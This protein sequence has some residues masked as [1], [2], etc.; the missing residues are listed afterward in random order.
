MSRP[1]I[2][3]EVRRRVAETALH[4]C[5]YCLTQEA[6]TGLP[7]EIDHIIPVGASGVSEEMNLWLACPSCNQRKAAQTHGI[8]PK[9]GEQAPLF[10]PREH[11]WNDHFAWEAGG[12][13]I[14]GG[15]PSGR[16]TVEALQMNNSFVVRAR[17]IWI[18]WGWHPP[19]P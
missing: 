14:I 5:G 9:T 17:Q 15:T 16:V 8:D 19:K 6:V 12:L 10:N 2:S 4:R 11:A 7:M 18:D 13:Y 3:K 1:Y